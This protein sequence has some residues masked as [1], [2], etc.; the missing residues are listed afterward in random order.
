MF[1]PSLTDN[2]G[3]HLKPHI[4]V[5]RN[6]LFVLVFLM[7]YSGLGIMQ[8]ILKQES[9][10]FFFFFSES[11]FARYVDRTNQPLINAFVLAFLI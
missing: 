9:N 3:V 1:K 8:G 4:D 5:N 7:L 2:I 6:I 11:N 10:D